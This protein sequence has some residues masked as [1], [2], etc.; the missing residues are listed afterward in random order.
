MLKGGRDFH[1]EIKKI[2]VCMQ[3]IPKCVN[4]KSEP[5]EIAE[6]FA[7]KSKQIFNSNPS[8]KNDIET[9]MSDLCRM[10]TS[11]SGS[12]NHAVI[13][14]DKVDKAINHLKSNKHDDDC[15]SDH[16][17]HSPPEIRKKVSLF[18]S[19]MLYGHTQ[20]CMHLL[21]LIPIINNKL[22][23]SQNSDNYR[24][25]ALCVMCFKILEYVLLF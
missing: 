18:Y 17:I 4:E 5:T 25:I 7:E 24:G 10:I 21:T 14:K 1:S 8:N 20:H 3:P 12:I 22:G 23:N 9:L 11:D 15:V 2:K 6:L 13:T 16:F 19:C